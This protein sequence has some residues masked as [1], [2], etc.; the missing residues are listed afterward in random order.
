MTLQ[1]VQITDTHISLDA[2]QRMKDL[3]NCIKAINELPVQ[4]DLVIHTGDIAHTGQAEEYHIAKQLLD[5]LNTPY[6]VIPGNRDRRAGILSEFIDERYQLPP[7]GWIQYSIEQYPVRLL[8]VDTLDEQN[9]K[10]HLCAE[11]L[12][13]LETMLLADTTKPTA[14]FLHHP[15]YEATGIPDPFQYKDWNDVGKLHSLL[16]RF[17]NICGMYC[18]HVHRFIDGT[19]A[20]V[21]A[22]AIS[23]MAG[24]LRKGEVSDADR[25]L[26]VFKTLTLPG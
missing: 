25:K 9:N 17:D 13:H 20:G 10:G 21:Q 12:E 5:Q 16:S 6:F 23:C 7:Q 18:G 1:L 15:P 26:P 3:E 4:P 22:S 14:L 8:M 11:R 24:D 19:I 2:P